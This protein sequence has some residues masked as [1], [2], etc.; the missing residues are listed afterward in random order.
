MNDTPNASPLLEAIT[1][2]IFPLIDATALGSTGLGPVASLV[3]EVKAMKPWMLRSSDLHE[4]RAH[5]RSHTRS[6]STMVFPWARSDLGYTSPDGLIRSQGNYT[7]PGDPQDGPVALSGPVWEFRAATLGEQSDAMIDR[8]SVG[9][10]LLSDPAA[11]R[12]DRGHGSTTCS[13]SMTRSVPSSPHWD[14]TRETPVPHFNIL[15][16]C[17]IRGYVDGSAR[18]SDRRMSLA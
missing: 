8:L 5:V 10:F 18:R 13:R 15:A 11:P 1:A 16:V 2:A 4:H 12:G 17:L 9:S 7:P 14:V 6:C 3:D